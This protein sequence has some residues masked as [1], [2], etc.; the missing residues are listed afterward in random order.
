MKNYKYIIIG[1]GM[2]GAAALDAI[3]EN[4]PDGSLALFSEE[5]H[6]PYDRPPLSKGLWHGTDPEKIFR[7]LPEKSFDL[8]LNTAISKISPRDKTVVDGH[9]EEYAY[10]KLLIATGGHPITIPDAPE[11]VIA[12]RTLEDYETLQKQ[13]QP[14]SEICVIGGGFIG[15]EIA[16]ALNRNGHLVTMIFPEIGISGLRFPDDL[17]K[18]LNDYYREKGVNV[19]D[20]YL[21][22]SISKKDGK[23]EVTFK[24]TEDEAISKVTFDKVIVGIGIKPNLELA[25][26]ANLIVEDGIAVDE[27]LKTSDPNIFAAGDVAYFMNI[28]LN[29]RTRVEHEDHAKKSGAVAGRNMCG[30]K[31]IYDHFPFFYSDLFDLGYEAI[32]EIN[33]NLDTF[34]DWIEPFKK[35]TIYYLNEGK[36]RGIIFWNLWG[37]VDEGRKL[38]QEGKTFQISALEGLFTD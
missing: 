25:K 7:K 22:E 26:K 12:F 10:Q 35:G 11:G 37:K 17:A 20:G 14:E 28:P 15:S 29:K 19:F 4:D 2:T 8:Y 23:Y 6:K 13:L 31:E 36:I 18:F 34:S 21:V 3:S 38:I 5:N 30:L 27:Y 24:N 16:A 9:G 33:K 1:G 32:G